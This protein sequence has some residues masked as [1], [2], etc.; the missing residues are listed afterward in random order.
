MRKRTKRSSSGD[1]AARDGGEELAEG[2]GGS[3]NGAERE[4]DP[5]W[6]KFPMEVVL[7]RG[8]SIFE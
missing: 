3:E 4:H 8:A 6:I 2:L 5:G 7:R 1:T